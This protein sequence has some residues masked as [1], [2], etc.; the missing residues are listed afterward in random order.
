M[1]KLHAN[2]P[3][4]ALAEALEVSKSGFYA[5]RRKSGQAPAAS[6]TRSSRS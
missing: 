3:V 4:S 6:A 5:H 1:E 2:Y